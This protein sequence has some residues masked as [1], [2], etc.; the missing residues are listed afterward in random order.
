MNFNTVIDVGAGVELPV[1]SKP[2]KQGWRVTTYC[3]VDKTLDDAAQNLSN[4]LASKGYDPATL[5][6]KETQLELPLDEHRDSEKRKQGRK[7]YAEKMIFA[8]IAVLDAME[9]KITPKKIQQEVYV[10]FGPTVPTSTISDS[11]AYRKHKQGVNHEP[12][13]E[14]SQ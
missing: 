3:Q 2:V 4:L 7:G 14:T 8:A 6:K 9:L 12:T 11:E 1:E 5:E 13:K 10:M